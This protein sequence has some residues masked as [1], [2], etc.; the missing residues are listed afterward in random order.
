MSWWRSGLET[1]VIG[2]GAA[3]MAFAVGF[4]IRTL[5]NLPAV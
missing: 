3:A 5:I 2:V 4:G 1:F